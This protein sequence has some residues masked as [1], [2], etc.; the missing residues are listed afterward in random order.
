MAKGS[1]CPLGQG[2]YQQ[3]LRAWAAPGGAGTDLASN[4]G[5]FVVRRPSG[6]RDT[7]LRLRP[8]L[9]ALPPG[10]GQ[11]WARLLGRIGYMYGVGG[12]RTDD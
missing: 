2:S 9:D 10:S 11:G 1:A 4:L 3:L 7:V 5:A 8:G 6:C 12:G